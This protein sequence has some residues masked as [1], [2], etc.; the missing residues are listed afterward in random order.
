MKQRWQTKEYILDTI[1][2][3]Y[4]DIVIADYEVIA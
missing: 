4:P 1:N 3:I 2:I